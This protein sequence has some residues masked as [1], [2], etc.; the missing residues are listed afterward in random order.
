MRPPPDG[1]AW[2]DDGPGIV[3]IDPDRCPAGHPMRWGQRAGITPCRRHGPH[4][5]WT[6]SCGQRVY[7][8]SGR[9]VGELDCV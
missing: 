2:I 4:L 3:L 8:A 7:R 6:C 9:F 5:T 1:Y